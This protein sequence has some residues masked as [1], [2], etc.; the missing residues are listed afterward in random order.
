M[1]IY[2]HGWGQDEEDRRLL[3]KTGRQGP[4]P[5]QS[6]SLGTQGQVW[7]SLEDVELLCVPFPI[8]FHNA[9]QVNLAQF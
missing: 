3:G 2:S 4:L 5:G 1:V 8:H 6:S 7:R 9:T